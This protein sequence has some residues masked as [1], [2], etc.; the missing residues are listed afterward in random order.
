MLL[1]RRGARGPKVAAIQVLLNH[2]TLGVDIA[3]D[4]IFGDQTRIAVKRFQKS[5]RPP[6]T[7]DGVFGPAT[8]ATMR[9]LSGN[10]IVNVIDSVDVKGSKDSIMRTVFA[11]PSVF[12]FW[13]NIAIIVKPG[14]TVTN[15][16]QQIIGRTKPGSI[17]LLRFFGHGSEG[18]QG[19][20][21]GT[22][23]SKLDTALMHTNVS[24]PRYRCL[25]SPISAYMC[26]YGSAELHGCKTGRG[27]AGTQLLQ[28]LA[29][30]WRVPVSAATGFQYDA[31]SDQ[32][33]FNFEGN[34]STIY[35]G[36]LCL[37]TWAQQHALE[38]FKAR[39]AV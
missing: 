11:G 34:V 7:V 9:Q 19:I 38:G 17:L 31:G 3:V 36:G 39:Q 16:I 1:L 33:V 6:L 15:A 5:A 35:P 37:K 18:D 10:V 4:G 14:D 23:V 28:Q 2:F 21:C 29:N 22:G 32:A 26:P 25:L 13:Q 12:D 24:D 30:L 20:S 27:I 8:W